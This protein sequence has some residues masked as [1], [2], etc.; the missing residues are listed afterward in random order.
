MNIVPIHVAQ[1]DKLQNARL[2]V[3][4][5]K[6]NLYNVDKVLHVIAAALESFECG[7]FCSR[8][9]I[10]D[11]HEK[12]H[13]NTHNYDC[14]GLSLRHRVLRDLCLRLKKMI[15]LGRFQVWDLELRH[16]KEFPWPSVSPNLGYSH[17][18]NW[19]RTSFI[20]PDDLLAFLSLEKIQVSFASYST[21]PA[22]NITAE[23]SGDQENQCSPTSTMKN[24]CGKSRAETLSKIAL[25]VLDD[26]TEVSRKRPQ[27]FDNL[28]VE[29]DELLVND[30][31]MTPTLVRR[32]LAAKIGAGSTCIVSVTDV[33]LRWKN[34]N[35]DLVIAS[36]SNVA[37]RVTRWKKSWN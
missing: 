31:T 34:A 23:L 8:C 18:K 13:V 32:A 12:K 29:I 22:G 10:S 15:D 6:M 2:A 4:L 11:A 21:D 7:K 14:D 30:P 25:A 5:P 1:A 35:G 36:T 24:S 37:D 28:A 20:F 19:T 3:T 16:V 17:F 33:G 27:R 26:T 9:D